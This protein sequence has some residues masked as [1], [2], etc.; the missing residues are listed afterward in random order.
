MKFFIK[1]NP[2]KK[3][4]RAVTERVINLLNEE[5]YDFR[6]C[7]E[8]GV[9]EM[10]C[11]KGKA[12]SFDEGILWCDL[13]VTIGGDGT[14][15][16]IG[17]AAAQAK[18][19]VIGV[20]TGR[21]GFLTAIEGNETELLRNIFDP[22]VF[23]VKNHNFIKAR[24]NKSKWKYCLND[25]VI[26]KCMYSNTVDLSLYS[27]ENLLMHF[28]GDGIILATSTGSTAYSLS[29]G[30]PIV[31]SDLQAMVIS[32]VA[33]HTL[34]RTS[35]VLAKDKHIKIKANDR[36][37]NMATI[38]FDGADYTE[39]GADDEIEIELS[40]KFISIYTLRNQ[41][42]FEKVDKKLKSR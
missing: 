39:I 18:K 21:I 3:N 24:V 9:E 36:S 23:T 34:N 7:H 33:P 2:S 13:V 4:S 10:A 5:G 38:A 42:Q 1:V 30:G 25:I 15:L 27:N 41:G 12:V 28:A 16:S 19:A 31:D 8:E 20:N 14:M 26:S 6:V 29:V 35:M 17:K 11:C 22:N 37:C 32:P 40:S